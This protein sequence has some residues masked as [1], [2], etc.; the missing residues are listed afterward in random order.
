MITEEQVLKLARLAMLKL[1]AATVTKL[2]GELSHILD[3]VNQLSRYDTK[4]IERT[5]HVHG[6]TNVFREDNVSPPLDTREVLKI[7]PDTSG[8]FIRVPIIVED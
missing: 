4:G 6:A 2:T 8:R 1:D 7:T 3:Y 5:S